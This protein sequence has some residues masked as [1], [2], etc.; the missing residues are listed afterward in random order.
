MLILN[1]V[2][3]AAYQYGILIQFADGIIRRV[4]PRLFAYIADYPEK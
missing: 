3:M 2:F 4:F 1:A